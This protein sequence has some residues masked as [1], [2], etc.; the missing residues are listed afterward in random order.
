MKPLAEYR[1]RGR[2]PS[3]GPYNSH[4]VSIGIITALSAAGVVNVWL[5]GWAAVCLAA[6]LWLDGRRL[7]QMVVLRAVPRQ[8]LLYGQ[9]LAGAGSDAFPYYLFAYLIYV[10]VAPVWLQANLPISS[11]VM[12]YGLYMVIRSC[13]L[14]RYLWELAFHWNNPGLR[15]FHEHEANFESQATAVRHVTWAYFLGNIGLIVR[16]SSQ[17]LTIGIFEA[18]RK[19]LGMDLANHPALSGYLAPVALLATLVWLATLWFA[20]QRSLLIYY[21]THRTFHN[22]RALYDSVH[23]IHH[24]AVL[25][26]PLDSGTISPAEFIISEMSLPAAAIVPNWWWVLGQVVIGLAGHCP[27]HNA[28]TRVKFAEHH[29]QHHR[30]FT[31]NFGLTGL[32]ASDDIRFGTLYVPRAPGSAA[33]PQ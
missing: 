27:A 24:R 18:L 26:T 16:C 13:W 2:A 5:A 10:C 9:V 32:F 33:N 30:Y 17:V 29:L 22:C 23:C 1:L 25:P 8:L 31:V 6:A 19:R 21:R 11:F 28:G 12:L 4:V 15:T 3:G 20:V 14:L 7:R